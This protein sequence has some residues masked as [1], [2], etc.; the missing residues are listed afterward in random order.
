MP[1]SARDA[2]DGKEN[3]LGFLSLGPCLQSSPSQ[4]LHWVL[5]ISIDPL[6]NPAGMQRVSNPNITASGGW[7][8]SITQN[9]SISE[10]PNRM[11]SHLGSPGFGDGAPSQWVFPFLGSSPALHLPWSSSHH[12]RLVL[13]PH[14]PLAWMLSSWVAL[15]FGSLGGLFKKH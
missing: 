5:C 7:S 10:T 14:R 3:G 6:S 11:S 15:P 12:A 8:H 9:D 2:R 13:L 4:A 1:C